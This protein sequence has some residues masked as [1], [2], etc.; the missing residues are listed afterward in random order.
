MDVVVVG[1]GIVGLASAYYLR[2][3]G[4]SVTLLEKGTI[5]GGN[6][7]RANGGIRAQF[8]SPVSIRLS[9][10]SIAVW[11]RFEAEF[12][13]DIGYF[14]PGYL[15]VARTD[16]TA[17]QLRKNVRTQR[18]HGLDSEYLTPEEATE[19]CPGLIT[20]EYVGAAYR[21]EDGFA[22]P[23]LAAQGYARAARNAGADLRTGVEVT[24][25]Q[26]PDDR[27]RA[28][29]TTEG[30][31]DTDVVVNAAGVWA[32]EIAAMVDS[33]LP[34]TPKRRQLVVAKPTQPLDRNVPMTVDMDGDVH[35]RPERDGTAIVGGF[36]ADRDPPA[37]PDR[38]D[39]GM[40]QAWARTAIERATECATYF[41]PDTRI[42]EGWA[43]LYAV[44]PDH[45]P[46][47][48]E[49]VPGLITAAGFSGHGFMQAPATGQVV[50]E[51]AVDGESRT[52][53]VSMLDRGRFD[54]GEALEEGTVID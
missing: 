23:H 53:D 44:T 30:R 51:L 21:G 2:E 33:Q 14:R 4:V 18:E 32:P 49:T 31:I 46:I 10:E 7:G 17:N 43:G 5:A 41:G 34:I 13:T 15:F 19:R 48:E 24:D 35:F 54:R 47:I 26:H 25:I 52:V 45:H 1:G 3:R 28:V 16:A 38:F 42:A 27:I 11:E 29:E 22:D 9:M 12:E 39:R 36:F 50:A 40:D 20:T 37:D 8:T 6:T